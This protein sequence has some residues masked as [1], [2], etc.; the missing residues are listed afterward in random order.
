MYDVVGGEVLLS[1]GGEVVVLLLFPRYLF[2]ESSVYS[3]YT[4]AS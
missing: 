4:E 3:H 1:V 2:V